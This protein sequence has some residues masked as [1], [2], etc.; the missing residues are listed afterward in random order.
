M[1]RIL[2]PT[3]Q[4]EHFSESSRWKVWPIWTLVLY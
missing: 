3:N 4:F 2:K 1:Q